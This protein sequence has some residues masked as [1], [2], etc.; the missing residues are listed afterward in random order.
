MHAL[1]FL[2]VA[3]ALE[4]DNVAALEGQIVAYEALL[5]RAMDVTKNNYKKDYMRTLIRE[6]KVK[7]TDK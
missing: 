2:E 3:L 5:Q 7:P 6:I 4:P 1:H